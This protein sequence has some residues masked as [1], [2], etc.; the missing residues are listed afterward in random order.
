M[1]AAFACIFSQTLSFFPSASA[2]GF[3]ELLSQQSAA[4]R[5]NMQDA[6]DLQQGQQGTQIP[7][8]RGK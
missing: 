1:N 5:Q 3:A 6:A 7:W 4:S 8:K 2:K